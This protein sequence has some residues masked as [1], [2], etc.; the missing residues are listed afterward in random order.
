M[1]DHAHPGERTVVPTPHGEAVAHV[2]TAL[3][4]TGLVVLGHGAGGGVDAPDLAVVARV[5]ADLQLTVALVEQ[6]YRV[7]GRRLPPRGPALDE[8]WRAV[9]TSLRPRWPGGPLV[10]GGRSAGARTACRTADGLGADGVLCLAFPVRP[11]GRPDAPDRL[12]ELDAVGAPVL[13]VQ[14][15]KDPFGLPPDRPGR[16]VVVVPGDH[17]LRSGLAEVE[18]EVHRWLLDV[19]GPAS[20]G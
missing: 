16:E 12:P 8:A 18:H 14:G 4:P 5:A 15:E 1:T 11:P 2:R 10:V 3:D 6:P 19:T 17:S 20:R 7:A 9:V 13:V